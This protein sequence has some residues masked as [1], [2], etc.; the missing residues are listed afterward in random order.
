MGDEQGRGRTVGRG[1]AAVI[2]LVLVA[3]SLAGCQVRVPLGAGRNFLGTNT[4]PGFG[5]RPESFFLSISG[6][7]SRREHG[8]AV[9]TYTDNQENTYS[10]V[11]GSEG[12]PSYVRR[13][14]TYD[15]AGYRYRVDIPAGAPGLFAIQVYDPPA[16][17]GTPASLQFGVRTTFRLYSQRLRNGPETT[18]VERS[19]GPTDCDLSNTWWTMA[20]V[21]AGSGPYFV[22]VTSPRPDDLTK[23]LGRNTFSLRAF[24]GTWAPCTAD[25]TLAG[26]GVALD[27]DCASIST[28]GPMG[29]Y[30]SVL[31][32]TGTTVPIGS[33]SADQ[34]GR[35]LDVELF[36]IAEKAPSIELLD[37]NGAPVTV[38]AEIACQDGVYLGGT[39]RTTCATGEHPPTANPVGSGL[40]YGPWTTTAFDICGPVP[41]CGANAEGGG[42]APPAEQPWGF[43]HLTQRTQYS[44]RT[45]RLTA[46]LPVEYAAVYDS[47]TQWSVHIA[48]ASGTFSDANTIRATIR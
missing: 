31:A 5:T 24:H 47:R 2:G 9:A 28:V 18:I 29:T 25:P 23:D 48:G 42:T 30:V 44:D 38:Q 20:S 19:F 37:P 34:A 46:M 15:P 17:A 36:D 33:I 12:G 43:A 39:G 7:C 40:T 45:V 22:Q 10:C 16:C 3:S 35:T 4:L 21:G 11:P 27:E 32:G 8:D 14:P 13:N 41:A 1:A 26:D 6:Y